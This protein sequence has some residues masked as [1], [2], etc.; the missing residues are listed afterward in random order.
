[1]G[2][3]ISA[4]CIL[5]QEKYR[6]QPSSLNLLVGLSCS[7]SCTVSTQLKRT[8]FCRMF[9]LI[10]VPELRRTPDFLFEP[11]SPFQVS[12]RCRFPRLCSTLSLIVPY[13]IHNC[14]PET[15]RAAWGVHRNASFRG[16][17]EYS[18][19]QNSTLSPPAS[20]RSWYQDAHPWASS[21]REVTLAVAA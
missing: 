11:L 2:Y 19:I 17:Q 5:Y 21:E 15:Q 3:A 6:P 4:G 8:L 16:A 20:P 13:H 7:A 14:L 10:A 12:F 9:E 18:P 1:M